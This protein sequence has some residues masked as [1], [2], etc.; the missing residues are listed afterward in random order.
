MSTAT[1]NSIIRLKCFLFTRN[2]CCRD[3]Q[4]T[5]EM[6]SRF[7]A[8]NMYPVKPKTKDP[9]TE[10]AEEDEELRLLEE[11]C[12]DIGISILN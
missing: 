5:E 2:I 11:L 1:L 12:G 4:V 3:F 7:N 10:K 8:R 9:E 6:L